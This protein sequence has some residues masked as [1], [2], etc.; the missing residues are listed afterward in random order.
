MLHWWLCCRR[1]T[2]I[3]RLAAEIKSLT[4]SLAS[5]QAARSEAVCRVEEVVSKEAQVG[6]HS[7]YMTKYIIHIIRP[8]FTV[9]AART[10]GEEFS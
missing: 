3:T 7:T 2:E 10:P 8:R 5:A 9:R 6:N 1:Q 4:E